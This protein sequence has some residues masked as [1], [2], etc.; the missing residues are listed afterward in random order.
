MER[1]PLQFQP[2][3][4][5]SI[6]CFLFL[7]L[8]GGIADASVFPVGQPEYSY[9]YDLNFRFETRTFDKADYQLGP[10]PSDRFTCNLGPFERWRNIPANQL[11]LFLFAGEDFRAVKESHN[12]GFESIRGGLTGQPWQQ[13]SVYADFVL[14]QQLAK[15]PNYTGKRARLDT[16]LPTTSKRYLDYA[17]LYGANI[18]CDWH[19]FIY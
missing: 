11:Q 6:C 1:S 2:I 15:D 5:S 4:T 19:G 10:Y 14:D 16:Y 18:S 3:I 8:A 12:T 9:L 7:T 13:V 17:I